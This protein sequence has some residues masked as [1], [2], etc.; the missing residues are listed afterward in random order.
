MIHWKIATLKS[1][2]KENEYKTFLLRSKRNILGEILSFCSVICKKQNCSISKALNMSSSAGSNLHFSCEY[3]SL[4]QRWEQT[5]VFFYRTIHQLFYL[6]DTEMIAHANLR[7]QT[8]PCLSSLS[9]SVTSR[10]SGWTCW[11]TRGRLS[12]QP[13]SSEPT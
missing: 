3:F 7:C 9:V 4:W 10:T 12:V 11:D 2:V 13:N 5:D 1:K 8:N 6:V